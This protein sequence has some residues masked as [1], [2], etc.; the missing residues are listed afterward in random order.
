MNAAYLESFHKVFMEG[1]AARC[2]EGGVK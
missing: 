1:A 2:E